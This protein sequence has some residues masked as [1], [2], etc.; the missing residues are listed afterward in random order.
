MDTRISRTTPARWRRFPVPA[1]ALFLTVAGADGG[2]STVQAVRTLTTAREAHSLTPEEAERA[3]PVHLRAV[4]TYYDPYIDSRHGALFVHDPTG[5]IFVALPARPVLPL[6]PGT[7]VDVAGVSGAGD[8]APIVD[9]ARIRV[10]AESQVPA[11]APRVS[12]AHMLTGVDDGQWVEV[13]GLA[14]SITDLGRN[15]TI[16]LAM[17]G[18]IVPA[19]SLKEE[20]ADYTRLID[21]KVR[22]HATVAPLFTKN[23]QMTGVRLFFPGLAQVR[24]VEPAPANPFALP[25]RPVNTLLRF[26]PNVA[27]VHRAHVRGRVTLQWPGRR[28]CLQDASQGL[29]IQTSQTTPL[30][31]GELAD[32]IGF[33]VPGGYTPTLTDASF[34][35]AGSRQAIAATPLTA[36][37]VFRG[38]HDAELVRIEGDLIGLD[39]AARDPTLVL[40]SG[41]FVFPAVLPY[42]LKSQAATWREGSKLRLTGVCSVEVDDAATANGEGAI[43]PKS[44]RL[45]LRSPRDVVL[46]RSPSWWTAR[47]ALAVLSLVLAITFAVLGWVV[48]LRLRVQRQ[49]EVIRR[50]LGQTAALKEA[51]EAANRAKS[52]FLANM[53]HEIR[54][55]MNGVMGMLDLALDIHASP[56][57]AE[58]LSMARSSADALLTIIN[59]ILDFS[60]IEAGRL[61]L[62]AIDFDL[63]DWL[64]ETLKAFALRAAEKGIELTCEI[65]PEVPAMVHADATRLRQVITNL[66]GNAL[67]FTEKGEVC[68]RVAK[69][70]E[71]GDRLMLHFNVIDTG[72]GIS[73]AKQNLI[74]EAFT[75]G[76]TSTTRKYGG[77]GLGLTIS[78]RL[79]CMMGGT[80]WV[81]SRPGSGANFHFTVEVKAACSGACPQPVE[82]ETLR[83]IPV[84]VLDDNATNRRILAET[85][86]RWGMRVSLAASG[87]AAL[88]TLTRA[89]QEGEP[90][91]LILTDAEMPEMDGF[92]LARQVRQSPELEHTVIIMLTSCGQRGDAARCRE[93]GVAVYLTKPVRRAEL[94]GAVL[95]ALQQPSPS[96]PDRAPLI[97]RHSL[98]E[99][100]GCPG[101]LRVLIA[102]D[103]VVN[104]RLARRLLEKRGHAVTVAG[105][106]RE[107]IG[108]LHEQVFDLVLMDVQMPEMD[109]FEATAAIRAQEKQTGGHVPIV[110][111]TAHAM[112]GDAERCLRAGMDGYLA[113]PINPAELLTAIET[114]RQRTAKEAPAPDRWP[115]RGPASGD[116]FAPVKG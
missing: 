81:E 50:Q 29:C 58:Y 116:V 6:R 14:H 70:G 99:E 72:T 1:L 97:T 82:I 102:E 28:L 98:R 45:L 75:Q 22:M 33:P 106:G 40:S 17:G 113:K 56:E 91:R 51:A 110:A 107:A 57:Q 10:I 24:I 52:E 23:R 111:L 71:S 46:L 2:P 32:V 104:Q 78:A 48:V 68:L 41:K 27:L 96:A 53:S 34:G 65:R 12:L 100:E 67:K 39:R 47:H 92:A 108:I 69:D 87:P 101:P 64:E 103:N 9:Q 35:W 76:D 79:V 63:S 19:T 11:Q 114:T 62:D 74:F 105:N 8:F 94:R 95:R 54:T 20:G 26:T 109:G 42:S 16:L 21:A 5:G 112:K 90:F 77:T 44:F 73:P 4:V 25:V 60:K 7:L 3:W 15:V 37:Q 36:E 13:E 83:G 49:T 86:S 55:P 18:G 61:E 59:D 38:D 84:L 30:E 43:R 66:V 89:A 88:A 80:I 85:L 31:L 93:E 115:D